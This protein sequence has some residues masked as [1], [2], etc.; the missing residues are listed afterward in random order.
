MA[1]QS[2]GASPDDSAEEIQLLC[3]TNRRG[4]E[5]LFLELKRRARALGLEIEMVKAERC[6]GPD[7]DPGNRAHQAV[8][9]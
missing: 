8:D 2:A 4:V 1:E 6:A 5:S 3:A 7:P 9:P